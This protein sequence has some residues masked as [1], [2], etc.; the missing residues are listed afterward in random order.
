MHY[1]FCGLYYNILTYTQSSSKVVKFY[2]CFFQPKI[3]RNVKIGHNI[4]LLTRKPIPS[5]RFYICYLQSGSFTLI[6][7]KFVL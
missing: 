2:H 6:C 7:C 4:L 5:P 3:T 1:L